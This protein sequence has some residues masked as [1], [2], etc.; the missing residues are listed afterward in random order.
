MTSYMSRDNT[1]LICRRPEGV[2]YQKAR[3][4]GIPTV[5]V[6]WLTDL[7]LG[8]MSALTQ[9]CI[10]IIIIYFVFFTLIVNPS[11]SAAIAITS[12]SS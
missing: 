10:N 8:N 2:K 11:S 3:E 4:W 5:S 12:R 9:V 6:Q 7:L 1:V